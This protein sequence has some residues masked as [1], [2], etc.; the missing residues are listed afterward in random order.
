MEKQIT[1]NFSPKTV[2]VVAASIILLWLAY[3]L[4][5]ILIL[6]VLAF[7][8][9]TAIKP[10]VDN[11]EKRK[12]PRVV[13]IFLIYT[14]IV[15]FF[16]GFFRLIIPPIS[17]Q[18]SQ[19]INNRQLIANEINE[20]FSKAPQTLRA[21]IN[22]FINSLPERVG[23]Y[24]SNSVVD[25]A[26]GVFSGLLGLLTVFVVSFYLLLERTSIEDFINDNWHWPSKEKVKRIVRKITLKVSL[27]VRGQL[28][29]SAAI[30]VLTFIGLY[31][32]GVDFALTLAVIAAVTEIIPVIGPLLGAIPAIL[33]AF[34]IS[35]IKALWVALLYLG[36]QQFESQALTPQIMKKVVGLSS[37][38]VIFALLVG[39]KLLGI[40]GVLIAVPVASAVTVI[41]EELRKKEK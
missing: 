39:A 16:F 26:L 23:R 11:L 22:T 27:W 8:I 32:L 12:V 4:K 10:T 17:S 28:I 13:S 24:T 2:F 9:S 41:F 5:D 30:G 31:I 19:L 15:L 20:A 7:I 35:P 29:L 36:I 3:F 33:I 38:T 14:L 21:P 40:L 1:V 6:F 34:A 18:T 37:V 25:N